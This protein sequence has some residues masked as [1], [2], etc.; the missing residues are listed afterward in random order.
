MYGQ[1]GTVSNP[2][3][4]LGNAWYVPS[5]G[6]YHF[7]IDG[8]IFSTYVEDGNGWVLAVSGNALTDESSY[9][10]TRTLTLQSDAIL[11]KEVYTSSLVTTVRINASIPFDVQS[12][13]NGVLSNLQNDRT[14][15]VNTNHTNWTGTGTEKLQRSCAGNNFSLST[16]IYHACGEGNNFHWQ[17]G[18][19]DSHEKVNFSS[20]DKNDL[21]LWIRASAVPLPIELLDFKA[22]SIDHETVVLEWQTA[23]ETNNAYF[24]IERSVDGVL[25]EEVA[26][27][28]GAGSSVNVL[29]YV[30]YDYNL[31]SGVYYYRLK[32]TD[33]KGQF[34]YAHVVSVHVQRWTK[35]KIEIY[36]TLA[37]NKVY[38]VGNKDELK[39][40]S[41]S[42]V[43]GKDVTGIIHQTINSD[44]E[45][46]L[47]MSN[48]TQGM[49]VIKTKST[50]GKVYKK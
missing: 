11:P 18:K 42:N 40:V 21:N 13:S 36:P 19:S 7:N 12:S 35:Y 1:E 46:I 38:L 24:T 34:S 30:A 8:E 37:E 50:T 39:Y 14:L 20:S 28:D 48:L 25:W 43:L 22:N 27:V 45:L 3:T 41:V 9:T 4:S 15:S 23:S 44:T 10:T 31:S 33:F 47:D 5:S 2:Y 16:H 17:V 32:Q 49:Y 26:R 6:I 29:G